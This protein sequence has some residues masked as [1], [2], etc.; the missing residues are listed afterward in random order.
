MKFVIVVNSNAVSIKE[1][2]KLFVMNFV[3]NVNQ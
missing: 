3:E 2:F 1:E